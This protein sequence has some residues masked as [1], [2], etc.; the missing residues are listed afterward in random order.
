M[1]VNICT[2]R[3]KVLNPF[4]GSRRHLL[5]FKKCP[6]LQWSKGQISEAERKTNHTSLLDGPLSLQPVMV[7][8]WKLQ[9]R[10]EWL[11]RGENIQYLPKGQNGGN[12]ACN[13][14]IKMKTP[15]NKCQVQYVWG[16]TASL[17]SVG[18][19]EG[20]SSRVHRQGPWSSASETLAAKGPPFGRGKAAGW[21]LLEAGFGMDTGLFTG[22]HPWD[23][24]P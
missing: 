1:N 19:E 4:D 12:F 21:V 11:W 7:Q 13:I 22:E 2:A 14:C 3:S 8:V 23:H 20:W 6:M 16:Q 15:W 10:H 9:G 24:C 5:H 18:R 17:V